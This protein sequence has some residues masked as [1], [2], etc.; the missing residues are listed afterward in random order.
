MLPVGDGRTMSAIKSALRL[1]S[2]PGRS[3]RLSILI[4]HRVL[5]AVDPIRRGEPDATRFHSILNWLRTWFN[6]MPLGE[7]IYRLANHSL[8]ARAAAIT[9][10]DGYADN[11][12][13]AVPILR[14]HDM[15]ATFFI[16]TRYLDGGCM[17]N[18]QIEAAIK[19]RMGSSLDLTDLGLGHHQI[20][21]PDEARVALHRIVDATKYFSSVDRTQAADNIAKRA[22]VTP[23][24]DLMMTTEQLRQI[25]AAGMGVGAHT[26]TH[27]ILSRI[28]SQEAECEIRTGK[29]ALEDA[30]QGPIDIFAYPNGKPGVDYAH[31]HVSLVRRMGFAA[32]VTTGSGSAR[33]DSDLMQLPRFTPWD[34]NRVKFGLRLLANMN[35]AIEQVR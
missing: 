5:P 16:A 32:A 17:W 33:A 3:A 4:F 2:P 27:P 29:A 20:F 30:L 13:I 14:Q 35:H 31:E 10:D 8:P 34:R 28:S 25:W 19:G 22:G 11:C 7:A 21:S 23:P 1:A 24:A 6:V 18:D 9:F 15:H 26:D 12:T